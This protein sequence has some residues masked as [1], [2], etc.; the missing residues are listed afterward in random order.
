VGEGVAAGGGGAAARPMDRGGFVGVGA[1]LNDLWKGQGDTAKCAA[2]GQ[3]TGTTTWA[4]GVKRSAGMKVASAA[5][6]A[7]GMGNHVLYMLAPVPL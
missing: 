3:V 7:M 6:V 4:V 1:C 2:T 5:G